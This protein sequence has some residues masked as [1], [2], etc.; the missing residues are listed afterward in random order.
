V[1]LLEHVWAKHFAF[2]CSQY[3]WSTTKKNFC[4][5]AEKEKI[6][7]DPAVPF[8]FPTYTTNS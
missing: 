6:L 2:A 5:Y 7:N 3:R 1:K 8:H 4:S